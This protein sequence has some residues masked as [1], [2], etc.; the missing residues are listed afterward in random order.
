MASRGVSASRYFNSA[1]SKLLAISL[2]QKLWFV[3]IKPF[4][5]QIWMLMMMYLWTRLPVSFNAYI[6][7]LVAI[8]VIYRALT[9]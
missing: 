6:S 5:A 4:G 9:R 8:Q 7:I 1:V 3:I 2:W